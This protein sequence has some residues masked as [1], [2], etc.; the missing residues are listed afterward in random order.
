MVLP[1]LSPH[2]VLNN[3]NRSRTKMTPYRYTFV[4]GKAVID[5]SEHK[6]DDT[7]S[8]TPKPSASTVAPKNAYPSPS[9]SPEACSQPIASH[10]TPHPLIKPLPRSHSI[11][12]PART[13]DPRIKTRVAIALLIEGRDKLNRAKLCEEVGCTWI[14]HSRAD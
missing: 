12:N 1:I 7:S 2:I 6:D 13:I 10:Q 8:P 5:L 4:N 3:P 9:S 14:L 11:E